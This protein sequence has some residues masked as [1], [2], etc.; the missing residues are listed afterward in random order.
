MIKKYYITIL[1]CNSFYKI[2]KI[3]TRHLPEYHP[4]RTVP[5][6]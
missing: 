4:P 6:V 1:E 3:Q 5:E 2:V